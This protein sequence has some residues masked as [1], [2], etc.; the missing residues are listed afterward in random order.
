MFHR[1]TKRGPVARRR[2]FIAV[3][4]ALMMIPLIG[5][6]ALAIDGGMMMANRRQVQAAVDSAA[7]AA[8]GSVY[9]DISGGNSPDY[10]KAQ[11]VAQQIAAKN[12]YTTGVEFNQPPTQGAYIGKA[13]YLEVIVTYDQPKYFSALLSP[14]TTTVGGHAVAQVASSPYSSAA[15]LVLGPAGSTVTLSG[16]T[17]VTASGGSVVVDSTSSSSVTSSG[18]PSI[19]TPELDLSGKISYSGSN[20]N[21]AT[22]TKSGQTPTPDPLASLPTPSTSGMTVQSNSTIT[23]SGSQTRTLSPGVYKGGISLSGSASVVLSPGSYYINGGGISLSGPSGISGSGV[24]IY[25]TGG[26]INLSGTGAITLSP[27]TTGTYAGLTVFQDRASTTGATMS[28]GS[29]FNLTGT[30]YFPAAPL[31]L[32][33][34][35][36]VAVMG[37]QLISKTLTFSGTAGI[38]V[39]YSAGSVARKSSL[40]LVE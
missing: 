19:A 21:K 25:N 32:S 16:T 23:L 15:I 10:T 30:Y 31:T 6:L 8:A 5:M 2:G 40:A 11:S 22:T 35:S 20:P 37:A 24:F 12:G 38:D 13:G 27:M 29:N 17:K 9:N 26:G 34:T 4:A 36:G 33:G 39:K 7:L 18:S 14:A 28:G 1:R 3:F